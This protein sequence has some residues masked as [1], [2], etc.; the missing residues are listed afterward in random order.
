VN[1]PD[2][3]YIPRKAQLLLFSATFPDEVRSFA[4]TFVPNANEI[5]LHTE[6]LSVEGIKQLYMDCRD[7]E[8]KYEVL[9]GLYGVMNIGQS[10]IFVDVSALRSLSNPQRRDTADEIARRMIADGHIVTVL[11]GARDAAERDAVMDGF[12]S[13]TSKVLIT[14]NVLAR[15]IDVNQVNMVINYDLPV[16]ARG[17]PDF[18]TYLHR[19]GRTGRFG[20]TGV[21]IAFI[22]DQKS[23]RELDAFQKYFAVEMVKIPT[24]DWDETEEIIKAGKIWR[25]AS[26]SRLALKAR[27]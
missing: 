22:H 24:R 7:E 8:H 17:A 10:I 12:R 6:E 15:G 21:S 16:D 11:H 25:Y 26:R 20:R 1:N 13:G 5:S 9:V 4:H 14:T 18:E 3:R 27:L 2:C 23:W 19:V